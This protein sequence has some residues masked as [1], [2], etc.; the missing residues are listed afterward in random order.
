MKM[1]KKDAEKFLPLVKAWSEGKIIEWY[2]RYDDTWCPID[3][4]NVIQWD[5]NVERYRIKKD[6]IEL[7]IATV[8]AKDAKLGFMVHVFHSEEVNGIP[9]NSII[10]LDNWI[11]AWKEDSRFHSCSKVKVNVSETPL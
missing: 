2:N 7:V 8:I 9:K 10:S 1:L 3:N 4:Q 6:K 5:L 11:K